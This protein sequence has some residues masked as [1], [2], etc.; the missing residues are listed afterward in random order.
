M[1]PES[2]PMVEMRSCRIRSSRACRMVAHM[3]LKVRAR[4][5]NSSSLIDGH[6]DG[7]V[8]ARHLRGGAVQLLH[9]FDDAPRQQVGQ[10]KPRGMAPSQSRMMLV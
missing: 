3:V 7:V 8:L 9:R 4:R 10:E 6:F 5:P 1:E 2:R